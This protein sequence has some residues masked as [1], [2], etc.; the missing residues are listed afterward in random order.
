MNDMLNIFCAIA[1]SLVEAAEES[2]GS[3][4]AKDDN[5]TLSFDRGGKKYTV[6]ITVEEGK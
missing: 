4:L 1:I 2:N 3:P 5:V 6:C